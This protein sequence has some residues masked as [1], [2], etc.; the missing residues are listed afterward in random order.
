M[1]AECIAL[2][3]SMRSLIHLRGLL[4]EINGV[5]NLGLD[6]K[7]S[8]ISTVY[9]DNRAA[10]ILANTSPPGLTPRSKSLA[11]KFHWLRSKLSPTTIVVK[12]VESA[13]NLADC[14]TKP[15]PLDKFLTARLAVCGW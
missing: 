3:M 1:K 11:V 13:A 12:A 7:F 5:F 8:T 9:E 10:E 6:S 4:F 15:L 2:S 14:L